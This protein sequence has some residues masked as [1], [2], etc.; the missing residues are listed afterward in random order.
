MVRE[1]QMVTDRGG[2]LHT[3]AHTH[4]NTLGLQSDW[5]W[6]DCCRRK[7]VLLSGGSERRQ[8]RREREED[9]KKLEFPLA[10]PRIVVLL[11]AVLAVVVKGGEKI[12][13]SHSLLSLSS[14]S[15]FPH[16]HTHTLT[17]PSVLPWGAVNPNFPPQNAIY[18]N[19]SWQLRCAY[20]GLVTFILLLS[21]RAWLRAAA[22]ILDLT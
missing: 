10:E 20:C 3:H 14:L 6:K 19:T 2:S 12:C 8:G 18:C 13:C 21:D 5:G 7:W 15:S 16:T 11:E 17:E 1:A 9:R 22:K 4:T